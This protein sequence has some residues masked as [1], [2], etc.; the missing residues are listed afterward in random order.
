MQDRPRHRIDRNVYITSNTVF[1]NTTKSQGNMAGNSQP[2][3][4]FIEG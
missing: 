2:T 4:F 3:N 1:E